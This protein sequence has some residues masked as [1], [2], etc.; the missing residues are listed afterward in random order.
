M[1]LRVDMKERYREM[2]KR[3]GAESTDLLMDDGLLGKPL[4]PLPPL[5]VSTDSCFISMPLLLLPPPT[6]CWLYCCCCCCCKGALWLVRNDSNCLIFDTIM[7]LEEACDV[8]NCAVDKKRMNHGRKK[9]NE[10]C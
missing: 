10:S 1:S 5:L 9:L 7:L 6:C 3:D 8:Y 4:P 2:D